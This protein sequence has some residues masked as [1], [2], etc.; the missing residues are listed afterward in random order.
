MLKLNISDGNDDATVTLFDKAE[1]L[2]GCPVKEY[3]KS[4]TGV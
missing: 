1:I 3:I 2:I 4:V